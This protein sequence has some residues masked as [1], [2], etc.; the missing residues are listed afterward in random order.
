MACVPNE[1]VAVRWTFF[2]VLAGANAF[3]IYTPLYLRQLGFSA[4]AIGLTMLPAAIASPLFMPFVGFVADRYR[5]RKLVLYASISLMALVFAAHLLP[6]ARPQNCRSSLAVNSSRSQR[7]RMSTDINNTTETGRLF[8]FTSSKSPIRTSNLVEAESRK[9]AVNSVLSERDS[10]YSKP[11]SGS[12]RTLEHSANWK[13]PYSK[14]SNDS[15]SAIIGQPPL[16]LLVGMI[17]LRAMYDISKRMMTP[18]MNNAATTR[19]RIAGTTFGSYRCWGDIA[20]G[21][22]T[23]LIGLIAASISYDIC[24]VAKPG[25]FVLFICAAS[26]AGVSLL[27]QRWVEFEYLKHRVPDR[28]EIQ[29]VVLN[30]HFGVLLFI[31][32]FTGFCVAFQKVWEF[33]YVARFA[34][35]G[36]VVL[37]VI[38][39]V[40]QPLVALWFLASGIFIQRLG[41]LKTVCLALFLYAVSFLAL[42]FIT[43]PWLV[44][45]VDLFQTAAYSFSN[46]SMVVYFAK[47][48]S[49]ALTA[50][51]LSMIYSC[52][53]HGRERERTNGRE[54]DSEGRITRGEMKR[55]IGG[56]E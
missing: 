41:E 53:K 23:L 34:S 52:F 48:G 25:Y 18:M 5:A 27:P 30:W 43:I 45:V 47:S 15:R 26:L 54:K 19:A 46:A 2:F 40:R 51:L 32:W 31:A 20:G 17:I 6:L 24:G 10:K 38:G 13:D 55:E 44:I 29:E 36:P 4:A 33:W 39:L 8:P 22:S 37:G 21:L 35:A 50:V 9:P 16:V 3:E 11:N 1:C 42:S 56:Y 14:P 49:V 12:R 28:T 7:E